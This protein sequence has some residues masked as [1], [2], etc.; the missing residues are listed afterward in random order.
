MLECSDFDESNFDVDEVYLW[1]NK[2]GQVAAHVSYGKY[3]DED[4]T[5]DSIARDI[6]TLEEMNAT[7]TCNGK[8]IEDTPSSARKVAVY[9]DDFF[10]ELDYADDSDDETFDTSFNPEEFDELDSDHDDIFESDEDE[11]F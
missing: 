1:D 5:D 8:I 6:E 10:A 3:D 4:A 7:E 9:E 11:E 2:L